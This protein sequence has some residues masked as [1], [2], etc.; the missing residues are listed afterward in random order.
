[1]GLGLAVCER[2]ASRWLLFFSLPA[3]SG[4]SPTCRRMSPPSSDATAS[5]RHVWRDDCDDSPPVCIYISLDLSLSLYIYICKHILGNHSGPPKLSPPFPK[6]EVIEGAFASPGLFRSPRGLVR[7][8]LSLS[9]SHSLA[10]CNACVRFKL[11][12]TRDHLDH[13]GPPKLAPP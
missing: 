7:R 11:S 3:V 8:A 5:E 12:P 13:L 9:L 4:G 10:N 2:G 1:M 6:S